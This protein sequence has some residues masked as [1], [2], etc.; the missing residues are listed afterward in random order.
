MSYDQVVGALGG[1]DGSSGVAVTVST[2]RG[3]S[4]G[5]IEA[6]T[7]VASWGGESRG[8]QAEKA[9]CLGVWLYEWAA[10]ASRVSAIWKWRNGHQVCARRGVS[11]GRRTKKWDSRRGMW[12]KGGTRTEIRGDTMKRPQ[13]GREIRN[14][15]VLAKWG[16]NK[17][18]R[19]FRIVLG[20]WN[21]FANPLDFRTVFELVLGMRNEI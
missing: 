21:G 6:M 7:V 2:V 1:D 5:S 8:T 4:W 18:A 15:R 13:G 9:L 3:S 20:V 16:K 12:T 14:G 10:R 19:V 11:N 17:F